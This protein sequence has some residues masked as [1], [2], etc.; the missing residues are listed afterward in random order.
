MYIDTYINIYIPEVFIF[1]QLG[2]IDPELLSTLISETSKV[3]FPVIST[4]G[5][6]FLRRTLVQSL[7]ISLNLLLFSLVVAIPIDDDVDVYLNK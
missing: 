2:S 1:N 3:L 5:G 4:K 6:E 7:L